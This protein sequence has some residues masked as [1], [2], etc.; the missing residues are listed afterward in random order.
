[1]KANEYTITLKPLPHQAPEEIATARLR[2]DADRSSYEGRYVQ[3]EDQV[4]ILPQEKAYLVSNGCRFRNK[5]GKII[6]GHWMHRELSYRK[7]DLQIL[8]NFFKDNPHWSSADLLNI[9][10]ACDTRVG[11]SCPPTR[12][13]PLFH[14]RRGRNAGWAA[15]HILIV[16]KELKHVILPISTQEEFDDEFLDDPMFAAMGEIPI[17]PHRYLEPVKRMYVALRRRK[18]LSYRP[19]RLFDYDFN[20]AAIKAGHSRAN[21]YRFVE[22]QFESFGLRNDLSF[23]PP[24]SYLHR[25]NAT[26]CCKS[27]SERQPKT[28]GELNFENECRIIREQCSLYSD[29]CLDDFL[30]EEWIPLKAYTRIFFCKS[31]SALSTLKTKYGDAARRQLCSD[32][33]LDDHLKADNPYRYRRFEFTSDSSSSSW[34]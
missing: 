5:I 22:A 6:S 29:R 25:L 28:Q 26:A 23:S 20:E 16:A 3:L 17:A 10:E 1:M 9:M 15:K 12:Y 31:N 19:D 18:Q 11:D 4:R 34:R 30:C 27:A 2:S 32:P 13:D 33:G 8:S 24:P 14:I 7:G 21:P